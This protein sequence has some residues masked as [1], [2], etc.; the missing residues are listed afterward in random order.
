MYSRDGKYDKYM[1]GI[2]IIQIQSPT[3]GEAHGECGPGASAPTHNTKALDLV[4]V[5]VKIK[6]QVVMDISTLVVHSGRE[7]NN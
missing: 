4:P 2:V 6:L 7:L 3:L 5:L 1:M